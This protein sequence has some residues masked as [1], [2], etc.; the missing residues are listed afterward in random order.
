MRLVEKMFAELGDNRSDVRIIESEAPE[1]FVC[2]LAQ[3]A[4]AEKWLREACFALPVNPGDVER[5]ARNCTI[6]ARQHL[7]ELRRACV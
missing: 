5:Y 3:G 6:S 1:S 2:V 4:I 7:K